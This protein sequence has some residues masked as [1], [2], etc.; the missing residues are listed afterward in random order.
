MPFAR[1]T[2]TQLCQQALQDMIAGL[3][4]IL[5][6]GVLWV[7]SRVQA[8]FAHLTYGYL[9]W[10]ARES[11]PYTAMGENLVGWAALKKVL[12]EDAT[13]ASGAGGWSGAVAGTVVP[14]GTGVT[15]VG[16]LTYTA[17]AAA[18]VAADG[19]LALQLLAD[20]AGSAG[21]AAVG[22]PLALTNPVAGV[23]S[24][25][26]VL[27]PGLTGG[28]DQETLDALRTRML[29]AYGAPPQGGDLADYVE[30]AG[31]VAGV[32]RT[33]VAPNGSGAGT[34]VVYVML[35]EANA[36]AG[37]FPQ[38]TNGVA[39]VETRDAPATGDQLTVAN[40]LWPKRPVTALVYV[41][42]PI[43]APQAF[44]VTGLGKA[45]TAANQAAITAALLDLFLRQGQVG[46]TIDPET[47]EAWPAIDPSAWYD[48]IGSVLG[49]QPFIV[50]VPAAPIAPGPGQLPVLS[51]PVTFQS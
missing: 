47:N 45:N 19:T 29:Q 22:S 39:A 30:W 32:T 37:G 31:D 26:A 6:K 48:A 5:P 44:T 35:D 40:A 28:A 38:G 20:T 33:W 23:P 25:G 11:V 43:A 41:C 18:T 51:V 4:G 9:D 15:G 1:P 36:A 10:I 8:N 3:G 46:G 50:P 42:A 13:A 34:V 14:A 27:A 21:N 2:F 7:I 49:T 24:A 12:Q 16:G 17:S